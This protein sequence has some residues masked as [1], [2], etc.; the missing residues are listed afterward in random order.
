M[1]GT[2]SL[3]WPFFIVNLAIV[4]DPLVFYLDAISF[5][6]LTS[7]EVIMAGI[8][9]E[10]CLSVTELTGLLGK[11][12]LSLI[13]PVNYGIFL[14]I[15][16]NSHFTISLIR[17]IYFCIIIVFINFLGG[18]TFKFEFFRETGDWSL[19]Q[20]SSGNK[21]GGHKRCPLCGCDFDPANIHNC[22]S[23]SYLTTLI[24][25]SISLS[26]QLFSNSN[27]TSD[28]MKEMLGYKQIAALFS[29][30]SPEERLVLL[31]EIVKNS[32][33]A[34][35]NLHNVKGHLSKIIEL[36]RETPQ[37]NDGLFI[38]NLNE[39]LG[40]SSTAKTEMNGESHRKLAIL[41]KKVILPCVDPDRRKAF[42][43]LYKNWLEI[44]FFLYD[45]G[46]LAVTDPEVNK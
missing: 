40:R 6:D 20:K 32:V 30:V 3:K 1:D 12:F 37:F 7:L 9:K 43:A 39:H 15:F 11:Q 23:Y 17:I 18:L 34:I 10:T 14:F 29:A 21:N 31:K 27:E 22:F 42:R 13:T 41:F 26:A 45:F 2:T 33:L 44:Q 24:P 28:K 5:S 19:L 35:D 25:K 8:V 4:F 38:S 36:E 46:E 16:A